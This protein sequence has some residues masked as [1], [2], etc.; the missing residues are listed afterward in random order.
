MLELRGRN[1]TIVKVNGNSYTL[2]ETNMQGVEVKDNWGSLLDALPED[3]RTLEQVREVSREI[4]N[5]TVLEANRTYTTSELTELFLNNTSRDSF[6]M[7][8]S[9]SLA[10]AS[11]YALLANGTMG[12]VTWNVKSGVTVMHNSTCIHCIAI[13][14]AEAQQARMRAFTS[15][16]SATFTVRNH[17]I[18]LTAYEEWYI[19]SLL[20]LFASLFLLVPSCHLPPDPDPR[21]SP[22]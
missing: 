8:V 14:L 13:F 22:N 2:P 16:P 6:N 21:P 18:P 12:N 17:P 20:S 15:N 10:Y 5:G 4:E 7:T 1:E 11:V 9:S 3:V 19:E